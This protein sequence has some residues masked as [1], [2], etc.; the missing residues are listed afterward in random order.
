MTAQYE[1]DYE[2]ARQYAKESGY[3]NLMGASNADSYAEGYC[4]GVADARRE[5]FE[6]LRAITATVASGGF[7]DDEDLNELAKEYGL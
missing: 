3:E 2:K 6:R 1:K 5:L 7:I 4:D